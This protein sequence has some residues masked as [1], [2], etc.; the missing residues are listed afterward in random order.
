MLTSRSATRLGLRKLTRDRGRS[1]AENLSGMSLG[2]YWGLVAMSY[3]WAAGFVSSVPL[4]LVHLFLLC[5]SLAAVFVDALSADGIVLGMDE[6]AGWSLILWMAILHALWYPAIRDSGGADAFRKMA[7]MTL[8]RP[9]LMWS[10]GTNL[11]SC[12]ERDSTLQRLKII[13]SVDFILLGSA[14]ILG[15]WLG[16]V[17]YGHLL[18]SFSPGT[19]GS[20]FNYLELADALALCSLLLMG[21]HARKPVAQTAV[22]MVSTVLLIFAYSRTS[23]F[24]FILCSGVYILSHAGRSAGARVT[25]TLFLVTA[26]FASILAAKSLAGPSA[27]PVVERMFALLVRPAGD[28][29]LQSRAL[30]SRQGLSSVAKHAILGRYMDEWWMASIVGGYAHN[31]LSFLISYGIGPFALFGWLAARRCHHEIRAIS[32]GGNPLFLVLLVFGLSAVA[33][34]RSYVWEYIWFAVGVSAGRR[35]IT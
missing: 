16:L 24:L 31:W 4:S 13:V 20:L 3:F 2:V 5:L 18:F 7:A 11:R 23:L 15:N 30:M 12:F 17:Q 8:L 34:S 10:V 22:F 28:P 9:L 35:Q 6:L 21:C 1:Y 29:S 32:D 25:L 33:V 26:L 27:L 14:V 19:D